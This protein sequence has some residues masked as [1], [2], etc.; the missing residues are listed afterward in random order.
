M[1]SVTKLPTIDALLMG[2]THDA[3]A[4]NR[5]PTKQPATISP[6]CRHHDITSTHKKIHPGKAHR[7]A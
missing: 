6:D 1:K 3:V 2:I 5:V 7:M 4:D